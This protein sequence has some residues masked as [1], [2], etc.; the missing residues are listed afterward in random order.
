MLARC[1]RPPPRVRFSWAGQDGRRERRG[2]D[3]TGRWRSQTNAGE[4]QP[5]AAGPEPRAARLRASMA[6]THPFAET[7]ARPQTARD[8]GE[9]PASMPL[10]TPVG[11]DE[12]LATTAPFAIIRRMSVPNPP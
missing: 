10:A 2:A 1:R 8:R 11:E 9:T 7:G 5:G 12:M 4:D 6:R 3:R